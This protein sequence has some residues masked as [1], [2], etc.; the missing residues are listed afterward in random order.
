M[1]WPFCL[2]LYVC[3][4]DIHSTTT[5]GAGPFATPSQYMVSS[6]L[7][8]HSACYTANL[9]IP[10]AQFPPSIAAEPCLTLTSPWLP[11]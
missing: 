10:I 2:A 8:Y 1:N 7:P 9:S 5:L 11:G 3:A 4:H 6:E